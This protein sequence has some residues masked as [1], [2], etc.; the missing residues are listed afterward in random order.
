MPR[1]LR[2]FRGM[3]GTGLTFAAGVGSVISIVGGRVAPWPSDGGRRAGDGGTVFRRI[4]LTWPGLRGRSGDR[5]ARWSVQETLNQARHRPRYR[6]RTSLLDV[7][8]DDRRPKLVSSCC[9]AQPR[10]PRAHGRRIGRSNA[11]HRT[12]SGACARFRRRGTGRRSRRQENRS[13]PSHIEGR[14]TETLIRV[15]WL[16][17]PGIQHYDR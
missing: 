2:I 11:R 6:C 7:S 9:G 16:D 5:R 12:T 15:K 4:I 10:G 17:H 1:W 8:C 3:V 13:R 14:Y